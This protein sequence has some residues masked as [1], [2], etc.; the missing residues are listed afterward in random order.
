MAAVVRHQLFTT[1]YISL[2]HTEFLAKVSNR[3]VGGLTGSRVAGALGRVPVED[4]FVKRQEH[5]KRWGFGRVISAA[6]FVDNIF[7][8]GRSATAVAC[9]LDDAT[10]FLRQSW[11]L[12]IKPDS[13]AIL[14]VSGADSDDFPPHWPRTNCFPGLGHLISSDGSI[15]DCWQNT[16]RQMW[17]AFWRN[18]ST[19]ETKKFALRIRIAQMVRTVQPI[20]VYRLTR[21][22][23]TITMAENLDRLQRKMISIAMGLRKGVDEEPAHFIRR[24]GREAAVFQ[25]DMGKWSRLWANLVVGW[26]G[27]VER[28]TSKRSWS[29]KILHIRDNAELAWRRAD[30]G[31]PFTRSKLGFIYRRW[32]ESVEHARSFLQ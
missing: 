25:R 21:Y 18:V 26:S 14:Q 10:N 29:S 32:W 13:R 8:A 6:S 4:M 22:P 23:F 12:S 2:P 20:L 17:A 15:S 7:A 1:V 19:A 16:K 31:R 3:S 24:R 30:M 5:W 27:H 9:I 28:N 11:R